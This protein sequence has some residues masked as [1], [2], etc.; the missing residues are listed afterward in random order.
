M[1]EVWRE[2]GPPVYVSV[3]AYLGINKPKTAKDEALDAEELARFLGQFQ[4]E[5]LPS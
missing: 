2:F 4:N 5:R 3:A 1:H